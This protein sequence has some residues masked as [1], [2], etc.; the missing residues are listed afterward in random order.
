MTE[1]EKRNFEDCPACG[2]AETAFCPYHEGF[3]DG[4]QAV[5]ALMRRVADDPEAAASIYAAQDRN[6]RLVA[7][8]GEAKP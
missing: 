6:S 8:E 2:E 4:E 3:A 7:S 1:T 5:I